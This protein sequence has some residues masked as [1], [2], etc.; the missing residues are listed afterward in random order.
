MHTVMGLKIVP[1]P[2]AREVRTEFKV[3]RW[4][5]RD[6]KRKNWRV[7]RIEINRPSCIKVGDVLY[8]HPDLV[9]KLPK[10]QPNPYG[11]MLTTQAL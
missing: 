11:H 1:H 3:T 8:M 10:Q 4:A 6:K 9:S 2:L 7:M 5:T